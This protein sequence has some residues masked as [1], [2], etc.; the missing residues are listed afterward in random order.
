[1][2]SNNTLKK[3]VQRR[4]WCIDSL[5]INIKGI[6]GVISETKRNIEKGHTATWSI[7]HDILKWAQTIHKISYEL[8]ILNDICQTL[9]GDIDYVSIANKKEAIEN[10]KVLN[11]KDKK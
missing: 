7:N 6:E 1:M 8:Y 3:I 10:K 2:S 9:L 4:Q 11:K 5:T